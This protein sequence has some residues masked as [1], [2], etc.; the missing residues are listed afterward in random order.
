MPPFPA[1]LDLSAGRGKGH[2]GK[3]GICDGI[4]DVA[5]GARAPLVALMVY[6]P[7]IA[8][9]LVGYVHESFVGIDGQRPG[10][11][12]VEKGRSAYG[13]QSAVAWLMAYPD[14]RLN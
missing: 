14:T 1:T 6:P 2:G 9:A 12:P 7:N 4:G 5:S 11:L 3:T 10:P 8:G 13:R